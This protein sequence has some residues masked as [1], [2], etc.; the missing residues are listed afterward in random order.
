MKNRNWMHSYFEY[1]N[2]AIFVFIF[3]NNIRIHAP[4][5]QVCH[6]AR[7]C[8]L[9]LA[10]MPLLHTVSRKWRYFGSSTTAR[11]LQR[12]FLLHQLNTEPFWPNALRITRL[13]V[14][15]GL[16][17][18]LTAQQWVTGSRLGGAI[19]LGVTLLLQRWLRW[20]E[21]CMRCETM[22]TW[23]VRLIELFNWDKA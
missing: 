18:A 16:Q 4:H 13:G 2:E 9:S 19:M 22:R 23:Q 12:L 7:A 6:M 17:P 21:R 8:K 1:P 20:M 14:L 15:S 3:M 5:D 11:W 10:P